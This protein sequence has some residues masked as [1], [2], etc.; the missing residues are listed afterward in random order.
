MRGT[1]QKFLLLLV[2][3]IVLVSCSTTN[4]KSK[5]IIGTWKAHKAS[6]YYP[7]GKEPITAPE[8]N[9]SDSTGST[10]SLTKNK[11]EVPA[12]DEA[13]LG[14]LLRAVEAQQQLTIKFNPDK[15]GEVITPTK[16]RPT[17]WKMKKRGN[18]LI[19]KDLESG[20]KRILEFVFIND[21]TSMAIQRTEAGDII[22]RYR[23]Q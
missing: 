18:E 14:R 5:L 19:V 3:G 4:P 10:G 23:K 12:V 20:Q 11:T 7:S 21:T 15:T 17:T 13:K 1:S 6:P 16:T 22:V 8:I 9:P 2:V